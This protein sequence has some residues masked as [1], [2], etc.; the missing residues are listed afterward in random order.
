MVPTLR[1]RLEFLVIHAKNCLSRV[2]EPTLTAE[3]VLT[4]FIE[5][6][7][8]TLAMSHGLYMLDAAAFNAVVSY[9]AV[10]ACDKLANELKERTTRTLIE[11]KDP[12]Q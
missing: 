7:E 4:D 12:F 1:H 3:N 8:D 2:N 6:L 9:A 10:K 11:T 5:R